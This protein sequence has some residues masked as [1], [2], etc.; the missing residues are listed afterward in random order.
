MADALSLR[1]AVRTEVIITD[2][3]GPPPS[4]VEVADLPFDDRRPY[5]GVPRPGP[6]AYSGRCTVDSKDTQFYRR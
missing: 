3:A 4:Q 6:H 2:Y 5:V 1:N